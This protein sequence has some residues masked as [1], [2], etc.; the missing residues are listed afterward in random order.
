MNHWKE[1]FK[2]DWKSK[3]EEAEK[4]YQLYK[5]TDK[6]IYLQQASNK[7]F[8]V[9]E[10]YLMYKYNKRVRS[11]GEVQA[12]V[13][14]NRLD[15]Q[16]LAKAAQLHYFYYNADLQMNRYDA[17]AIYQEVKANILARLKNI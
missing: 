9:V 1:I 11:Y 3:L 13:M 7:I 15:F 17:V 5:Q 14:H 4:E 16:L 10:N 2:R 12:L 6:L 8:S